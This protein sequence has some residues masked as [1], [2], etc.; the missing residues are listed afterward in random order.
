[1]QET[2]QLYKDLLMEDHRFETRLAIGENIYGEDTLMS[3][4]TTRRVFSHNVPEVGC[5]P[6]GEIYIEML[7]PSDTIPQ[8]ARLAPSVRLVSIDDNTICSEWL[9]KGVFFIDTRENTRNDDDLDILT[10]HGYDAMMKADVNYPSTTLS[11]PATDLDVINDIASKMGVEV[12]S[13][14]LHLLN[15]GYMIQYPAQYTMRETLGYIGAMY[16]GNWIIN[17]FGKL[18]F[19]GL[20]DLPKET[21]LLLDEFANYIT[22]GGDRISLIK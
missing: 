7:M 1:M 22:F 13:R 10:I 6:C 3:L 11:F 9:A 20:Y 14:C 17:D 15:R 5:C 21:S 4:K 8:M 2:S 19:I 12:D 18:Q 16:A